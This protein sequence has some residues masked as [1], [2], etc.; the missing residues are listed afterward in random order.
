LL[1]TDISPETTRPRL[2]DLKLDIGGFAL[3]IVDLQFA[4]LGVIKR[5]SSVD[6]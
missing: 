1:L 3:E 4:L 2:D 6:E 5:R